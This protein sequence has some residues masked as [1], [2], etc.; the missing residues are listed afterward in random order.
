[1][2]MWNRK[3]SRIAAS[4]AGG[5]LALATLLGA[6]DAAAQDS[7]AGCTL[8]F[9]AANNFGSVPASSNRP[10]C[11]AACNRWE[12]GCLAVVE[13][14]TRCLIEARAASV[15]IPAIVECGN[16]ERSARRGCKADAA[17]AS[18]AFEL[19]A[20]NAQLTANSVCRS[21]ADD[22]REDC[23]SPDPG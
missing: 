6:A 7:F 19:G 16:A 5:V 23:D 11:L 14:N 15:E 1:M 10:L 18:R 4:L 22:C 9:E 20:L 3:G 8:P 21:I 13:H 17:R 12:R 2:R